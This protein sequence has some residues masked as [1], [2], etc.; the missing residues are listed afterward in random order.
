[1]EEKVSIIGDKVI[2]WIEN[3]VRKL[4]WK[5]VLIVVIIKK[6][7]DLIKNIGKLLILRENK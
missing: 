6:F 5:K 2:I 7:N 4:K 3:V 1:M